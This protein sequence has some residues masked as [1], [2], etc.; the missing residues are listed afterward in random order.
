VRPTPGG[1]YRP[2]FSKPRDLRTS[3]RSAACCCMSSLV[4]NT[5][6]P[7]GQAL[8]QAGSSPT[9]TRSEHSVHLYTLWSRLEIRGMS[10][11]QPA[12][13]YP[14]PMQ[15]S[16]WKSTI[17]FAYCTIAPGAGQALRQPGS[18]QCMQPS[19]RISHSRLPLGFSYSANRMTVHD[20]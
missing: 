12:M 16:S 13:Q 5:S 14:Q 9:A 10:N 17:P 8:M 1:S 19:L 20:L 4:P 6:A 11:G 3:T 2:A 18:A 7:V 15:F